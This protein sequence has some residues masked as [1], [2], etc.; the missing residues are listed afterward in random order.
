MQ[1]CKSAASPVDISMKLV[2]SDSTTKLDAPFREAVGALMCS[3]EGAS[4]CHGVPVDT[5]KTF[6]QRDFKH[7]RDYGK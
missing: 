6:T 7:S 4:T 5:G 3:Q 2:S 1:D